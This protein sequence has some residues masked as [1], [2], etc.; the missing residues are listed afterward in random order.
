[1]RQPQA[2]PTGRQRRKRSVPEHTRPEKGQEKRTKKK[3][4]VTIG[5]KTHPLTKRPLVKKTNILIA[6]SPL[7]LMGCS[8]T[9]LQCGTDGESSFVNLNTTPKVLSQN[10]RAMGELCSFAYIDDDLAI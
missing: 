8:V 4:P 2:T 7:A 10:S 1:M 9:S 5:S 3:K 6:L